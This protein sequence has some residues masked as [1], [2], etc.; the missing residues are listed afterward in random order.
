[1]MP[2]LQVGPFAVQLPGLILLA[3]VWV[4]ALLAE[5]EAPWRGV[6][7]AEISN[8]TFIALVVGLVGAKLW[9]VLRY[10]EVYLDEPLAMLSLNP[11]TIAPLEGAVTGLIAAIIYGQRRHMRLWPTLDVLTP[12]LA[13]VMVFVGLSNLASGDAFGAATQLPWGIELW[14]EMRHPSQLY[15]VGMG[16]IVVLAIWR[17]KQLK[18]FPGFAFLAWLLMAA[19]VR[20]FLE[21]F[22]GDSLIIFGGFRQGQLLSILLMAISLI[23]LRLRADRVPA[24]S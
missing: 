11:G 1:M 21:A 16:L 2:I 19:V 17:I 10:L 24:E 5:R 15:N 13:G 4:G 6:S 9:Y 3:G 7:K 12:G 20:L 23:A 14:G 8:L 18:A 22:R